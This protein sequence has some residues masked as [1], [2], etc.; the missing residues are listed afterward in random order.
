MWVVLLILH[1]MARGRVFFYCKIPQFCFAK[2]SANDENELKGNLII[3]N[4]SHDN[5]NYSY[6]VLVQ[7]KQRK[8]WGLFYC[9]RSD[10]KEVKRSKRKREGIHEKEENKVNW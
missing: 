9:M 4:F 10:E 8:R 2:F 7:I 5:Y 6:H 3:E 1:D